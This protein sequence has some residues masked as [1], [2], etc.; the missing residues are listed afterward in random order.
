MKKGAAI[1][2]GLVLLPL[3]V[4]G[5]E[6][7]Q[8][9]RM[10]EEVEAGWT[11]G[12]TSV[13]DLSPEQRER[14]CGL[15]L[16]T[17]I[18]EDVSFPL[19]V[20]DSVWDWRDHNGD[21][22]MTPIRDQ[23]L[24][25]SCWAFAALGALESLIKIHW[26]NP[27]LPVDLS[28]QYL[29][30]CSNGSCDGFSLVGTAAFLESDGATDE[31]CF[32]YQAAD[33]PCEERCSDWRTRLT[34]IE[35][36][37]LVVSDSVKHALMDGP[38]Y[39]NMTV[40]RS[41]FFYTG[42][43]YEKLPQDDLIGSHVVVICGWNDI[44]SCW[45]CKNSWGTGW[46]EDGWFRIRWLDSHIAINNV[47]MIPF[48]GLDY[49]SYEFDDS[50]YG[51]GDGVFNPGEEVMLTIT[52]KNAGD[53]VRAVTGQL[54]SPDSSVTIT[55]SVGFYGDIFPLS[56]ATNLLDP[57]Q[58]ITTRVGQ[59]SL[60]L[61]L[62]GS[63]KDQFS[64]QLDFW[65]SV[66]LNQAHW[67]LD[68]SQSVSSSPA[69]ID[70]DGDG[71]DEFVVGGN[72]GNLYVKG[73]DGSDKP[74][75]PFSTGGDIV[76]SPSAGDLDGDG[77][78]EIVITTR[79]GSLYV[80]S[81][82]G[83]VM[84][85]TATPYLILGTPVLSDLNSD[86]SLEII[87]GSMDGNLHVFD[88]DGS[89]YPNFPFSVGG[90]IAAGVAVAD[91]NGDHMKD[92]VVGTLN[93]TVYAVSSSGILLWKFP[94]AQQVRSAPSIADIEGLK[95]VVGSWDRTLYILNS[96]GT[97]HARV[98]T[99]E[100]IKTSPSFADLDGDNDPEIIF[101]SGKKTYVC[102][103]DG[104][105]LA[106]WP[107]EA[108]SSIQSSASFSDMDNNGTPEIIFGSDDG[109][110]YAYE[111]DGSL[112]PYFPIPTEA[113]II[114][115]PAVSD[116]DGDGDIEIVF[117]NNDGIQV[118][119]Y[120][121]E[122]GS[123]RCW[124]MY[125]GNP[126]RTGY[127]GDYVGIEEKQSPTEYKVGLYQNYPNPFGEITAISYQL[128]NSTRFDLSIYNVMGQKVKTLVKGVNEPGLHRAHWDRTDTCGKRVSSG[129][130][131]CRLQTERVSQ[132]RK[133]VL[134]DE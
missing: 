121:S 3:S 35:S 16:E 50:V 8:I 124:N 39:T 53:T 47:E 2:I 5:D 38:L 58:L 22:W 128:S 64:E 119:D 116:L 75:F 19:S 23:G 27:S 99:D 69:I 46:G 123:N 129:I 20:I 134:L 111:A 43:V 107:R 83:A 76:A 21:N 95:V 77:R 37:E 85:Q 106:N 67:P 45:I 101:S 24:C 4:R 97:E 33:L 41:F 86:G 26:N 48:S 9:R 71:A 1:W 28:E 56:L 72:D 130:Y 114:S 17:G 59:I 14:L 108:Q 29:V 40:Y 120:K 133:I 105:M 117:G 90:I 96:N 93:D 109:D 118:I 73:V 115:S 79:E 98:S 36:W 81:D 112:M 65:I 32:P 110:L 113:K 126:Q 70:V 66:T 92:I 55:D 30:S 88:H 100:A 13:S 60:I 44:D 61:D 63:E 18:E 103:H 68:L 51:D 131:F 57:F 54:K 102:Q 91:L 15:I 12:R 10:I 6:L 52:L 127:Y 78:L 34:R 125:R 62:V 7:G 25:G 84:T 42:G 94:T 122:V 87:V 74:G 11:A 89:Q 104:T 49:I 82:S 80:L 132:T 31:D